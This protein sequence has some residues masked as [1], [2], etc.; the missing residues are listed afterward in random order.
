MDS[1]ELMMSLLP[2]P[3]T[4]ETL[5]VDAIAGDAE[6]LHRLIGLN[7]V[8]GALL[9]P[10]HRNAMAGQIRLGEAARVAE[11]SFDNLCRVLK[12]QLPAAATEPQAVTAAQGAVSGDWFEQAEL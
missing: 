9:D 12:G 2:N 10:G 11:V 8:F 3:L 5:L 7:P 4:T 1:Q 6:V